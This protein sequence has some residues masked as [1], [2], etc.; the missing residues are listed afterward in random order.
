MN[1]REPLK[2]TPASMMAKGEKKPDEYAEAFASHPEPELLKIHD[3]EKFGCSPCHQG[4]GRATTSIEKAHGNYEHWLWPLFPKENSQAGCQTCHAADMVLVS[5]DMQFETINNGK[6]LFRQRGCMGCHRYEGYDKEPEDLN[7][8]SQQI[9]QIE[10]QKIDNLKQ[11][12]YLMKQADAAESNEEANKLNT[13]A[14]DLKVANSK[15]DGRLQ[16][17]D[18]QSHSLMQDM[19]KVGPNLKDVRL[20]LNKNWIPVWLKKPTDFRPTTKMP[21][22]RLTD[23]QIQAI[24]AYIWQSAFTDPLAQAQARQRRARQ[25]T[26]RNSRMPGLPLH[27]RRR[28]DAGRNVRRESHPRRR[29]SQLRL[30]RALDSQCPPAHASLLPVREERHRP[31]GL[32]QEGPSLPVR[33]ATTANVPTMATNCKCRT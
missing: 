9:K 1:A 3:P 24:S 16:Q 26:I 17:L 22:F 4:N 15:L 23:H 7:S 29:E 21:N 6:D 18:F 13:Q 20:K 2:I 30:P 31:R 10:T 33:S 5:G 28:S 27:R 11:T 32:R 14:V 8:I 25:R 19:K 12:A